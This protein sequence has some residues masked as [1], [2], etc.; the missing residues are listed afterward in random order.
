[1]NM[2]FKVLLTLALGLTLRIAG[3]QNRGDKMRMERIGILTQKLN[4]NE[5]QAQKFWPVFN[6]FEG[7]RRQLRKQYR[8]GIQKAK[9]EK[10]L[11]RLD[12]AMAIRE[13]EIKLER[14]YVQNFRKVLTENQVVELYSF[15]REFAKY[16]LRGID[17][18]ERFSEQGPTG[19]IEGR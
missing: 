16:L 4:L 12:E 17:K 19:M 3:A 2:T 15:E 13:I 8:E 18:R 6:E 14:Q 11:Q 10:S 9:E 7:K 1:M 5:E